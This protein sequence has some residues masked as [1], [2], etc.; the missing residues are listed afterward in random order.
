MTDSPGTTPRRGDGGT[1]GRWSRARLHGF[2][3]PPTAGQW[4]TA[5]LVIVAAVVLVAFGGRDQP[6]A[7]PGRGPVTP[8]EAPPI[9]AV[10]APGEVEIARA[11]AASARAD[12]DVVAA[13]E[14]SAATCRAVVDAGALAVFAALDDADLRDCLVEAGTVVVAFDAAGDRPPAGGS[15]EVV[16]SRR[17]LADNLGD[18]LSWLAADGADPGTVGIVALAADRK[19]VESAMSALDGAPPVAGEVYLD[20]TDVRPEQVASMVDAG[21]ATVVL[22]APVEVQ[23][24]WARAHRAADPAVRVVAADAYDTVRT[25]AYPPELDGALAYTSMLGPWSERPRGPSADQR[26]CLE[27][28]ATA[29]GA[30]AAAGDAPAVELWCQQLDLVDDALLQVDRG[31]PIS[32]ALRSQIVRSPVTSFLGPIGRSG[33]GPT[34][35]AVLRWSAACSCWEVERAFAA[36]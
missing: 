11:F 10:A 20:G 7:A 33:W 28:Y 29:T 21:V 15:G 13:G 27:R 30:P 14:D 22:V 1:G 4:W 9:V 2:P 36:R 23:V 34:Q 12:V 35:D 32:R 8:G 26:R 18:V 19:A 5:A 6:A 24:A 3:V 31:V 16:S 17:G 25:E